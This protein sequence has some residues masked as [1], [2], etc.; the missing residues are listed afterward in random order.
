MIYSQYLDSGIVPVALAL[1]SIGFT[2]FGNA[3]H[4]KPLLKHLKQNLLIL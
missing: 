2:R 3:S 4:T 1:E